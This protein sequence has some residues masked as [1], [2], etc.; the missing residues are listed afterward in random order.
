MHSL[1]NGTGNDR[2]HSRPG[3]AALVLLLLL[4]CG[5]V[6]A[7]NGTPK[8]TPAATVEVRMRDVDEV[9]AAD[10]VIEAVRQATVS[11][12]LS[13]TVT[14]ILVDA[15]DRVEKGQVLAASTR[16]T[17]MRRWLQDGR[18]SPRLTPNSRRP[19]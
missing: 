14:Q 9:Y 17:P 5:A 8:A 15:G 10:A 1:R 2:P 7:D 3:R 13:G 11:A 19:A 18:T 12:Q 6:L 16:A 4:S